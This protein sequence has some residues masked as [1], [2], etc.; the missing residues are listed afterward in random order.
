MNARARPARILQ[1]DA[2]YPA[3]GPNVKVRKGDAVPDL[4]TCFAGRIDKKT[5][6]YSAAWRI[7]TLNAMLGLDGDMDRVCA[8]MKAR[9]AD[10][11]CCGRDDFR[12]EPPPREL[13]HGAPHKGVC[14]HGVGSVGLPVDHQDFCP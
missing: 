8:V 9:C 1:R 5:I 13:D 7:Q 11:G 4:S 12:Y 3:A 2:S 6:E 10:R 14:R